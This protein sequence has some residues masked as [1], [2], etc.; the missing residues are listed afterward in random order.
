MSSSTRY[1]KVGGLIALVLLV[2][3]IRSR[4]TGFDPGVSYDRRTPPEQIRMY[5]E[6]RPTC[7]YR[8]VGRV[9][10]EGGLFVRWESVVKKARKRA[11]ELGGDAIVGINERTRISGATVSKNGVSTTESTSIAGNVIRFTNANCRE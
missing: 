2:G 11:Y 3:C 5:G 1:A 7:A 4:V 10:A 8:E 9:T 6:Q